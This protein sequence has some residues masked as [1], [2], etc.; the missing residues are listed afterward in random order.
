MKSVTVREIVEAFNNFAAFSLQE[1]YDNSGLICG[2]PT[3]VVSHV[4]LSLDCTE[5]VVDEAINKHC[6]L[7]IA[8]HPILFKPIKSITG[9]DYV[10]RALI[11]A[12]KNDI[13]ILAVHTNADN[14]IHGV[15]R[16]IAQ[17]LQL[18][19]QQILAPKSRLLKK[20]EF[21][22]P[23]SHREQVLQALFEAGAGH[24]GNYSEC[25][26]RNTG[27]GTFK[28]EEGA[29]PFSGEQ[30]K[31]SADE[32]EK[33]ELIFPQYLEQKILHALKAAHPYEEVAYFI[34]TV[35]NSW[36][37]AGSGL[38]GCLPQAMPWPD[39]VKFIKTQL[40][41]DYFRH[42]KVCHQAIEQVAICG[43]SG[44]FLIAQAKASGAQAYITADIKYHEFFDADSNIILIDVGH[45]ESEK[46]TPQ[47]FSDV[48]KSK[49]PNIA[50]HFSEINTNPVQYI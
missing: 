19:N 17:R 5:E 21:Y 9:R 32:E 16:I 12:I 13:A 31:R 20:L 18:T 37:H 11:K 2:S 41:I 22:V 34:I 40:Q 8:H 4:L 3:Q 27:I 1:T 28:P 39:F 25:S 46:F 43:G 24:I 35:D 23:A 36:Q 38:I 30:G 14:V 10:E 49:F 44:A 6:N 33:V 29:Q 50:A 45:Y 42:T 7:I 15:N 48:L 47:L 26:F